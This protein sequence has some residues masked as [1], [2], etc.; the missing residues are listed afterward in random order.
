MLFEVFWS[1]HSKVIHRMDYFSGMAVI[2][3][4][5]RAVVRGTSST[6]SFVCQAYGAFPGH[7]QAN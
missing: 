4:L 2:A 7:N 6:V 5:N 3:H 1:S